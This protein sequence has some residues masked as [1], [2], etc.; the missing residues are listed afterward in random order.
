MGILKV[1]DT[2]IR[3]IEDLDDVDP[4]K[5]C[6]IS[7]GSQGEPMSALALMAA[8]ESRFVTVGPDDTV[9]LSSHP[10]PGNVFPVN[11]VIDGLTR[12]GVE[13]INTD[14]AD[15]HATGHA[16][17]EELKLYHS[18]C[19]PEW[20]VPVHGEYRH[21]KAH[22]RLAADMGMA[23]DH[24]LICEDGDQLMLT[25]DGLERTGHV[26][27]TSGTGCCGT[28]GCWPRRGSWSW[29][30]PSTSSA[31]RSSPVPRSSPGDGSTPPRPS[32]C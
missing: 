19:R 32:R 1:P 27:A 29:S 30:W 6:I 4:G 13:V 5:V 18:I 16:Q 20:F 28:D 31:V 15:V 21:M 22:A 24:V 12:L 26:P 23:N 9:I 2:A 7:T 25:D 8:N 17:R 14:I 3:E 10:I 11:R